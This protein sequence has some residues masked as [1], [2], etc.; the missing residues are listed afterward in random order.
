[1]LGR[2]ASMQAFA[3]KHRLRAPT[4]VVDVHRNAQPVRLHSRVRIDFVV[5]VPGMR[6]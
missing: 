2:K 6:R 1:M 3:S 4:D 5:L